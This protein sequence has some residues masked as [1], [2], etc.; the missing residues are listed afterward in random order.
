MPEIVMKNM[1]EI[2][3][4]FFEM[5]VGDRASLYSEDTKKP[6]RVFTSFNITDDQVLN[7]VDFFT[8]PCHP[9]EE[10]IGTWPASPQN[11]LPTGIKQ[12]L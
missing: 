6:V 12:I 3:K 2:A 11:L 10:F 1:M 4:E 5:P 8:H 9:L 7:W